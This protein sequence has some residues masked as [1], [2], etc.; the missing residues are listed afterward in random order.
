M[1]FGAGEDGPYF[2]LTRTLRGAC[3]DG[4]DH[5]A[6][7]GIELVEKQW[8]HVA[9][10]VSGTKGGTES[11]AGPRI[12]VD[13]E[14]IADGMISQT[15]SG[16]YRSYRSW[17]ESFAKIQNSQGLYIGHSQFSADPDF[18]GAISSFC[19]YEKALDEDEILS[20]MCEEMTTEQILK[21]AK[22]R[23]LPKLPHVLTKKVSLPT[24]LMSGRIRVNWSSVPEG[25]VTQ[26]GVICAK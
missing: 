5:A 2:F 10:T 13:G 26:V 22:E 7:S 20:V 23:F 14:L 18:C 25:V 16:T 21:L 24:S 17:W 11:S 4:E 6:D 15:S 19:V 9:F 3:Y 8:S 1:D 12:Y